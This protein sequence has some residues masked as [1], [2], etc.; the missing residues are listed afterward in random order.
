MAPGKFNLPRTWAPPSLTRVPPPFSNK[1]YD[2]MLRPDVKLN[3]KVDPPMRYMSEGAITKMPLF[4]FEKA[5]QKL[6]S[7]IRMN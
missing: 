5:K 6:F 2:Q 7:K 3:K 1:K 4:G